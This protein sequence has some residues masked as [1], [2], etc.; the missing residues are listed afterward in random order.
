MLLQ[1]LPC[2]DANKDKLDLQQQFESL[3][4]DL[5][6]QAQVLVNIYGVLLILLVIVVYC[7]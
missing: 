6:G 3:V 2:S 7:A 5:E 1:G 4:S